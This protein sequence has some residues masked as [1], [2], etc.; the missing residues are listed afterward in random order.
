MAEGQCRRQSRSQF[1][2]S[3]KEAFESI[4]RLGRLIL[5]WVLGGVTVAL[6][7]C[8][9]LAGGAHI[10]RSLPASADTF[11]GL[12]PSK[13]DGELAQ[14]LHYIFVIHGMGATSRNY[15]QPLLD[16]IV[17][18]GFVS[19]SEGSFVQVGLPRP[20]HVTGEAFEC[21]AGT[22]SPPCT[23]TTFGQYRVDRFVHQQHADVKVVVVTYFWDEAMA[24][25]QDPFLRVD[26][27]TGAGAAI[28]TALK[29]NLID[30]GFGDATAYLGA[31]G[32]LA[33]LGISGALCVMLRDASDPIQTP[34]DGISNCQLEGLTTQQIFPSARV[35]YAFLSFS[36]GSRMLYDVLSGMKNEAAHSEAALES[37]LARFATRT[38]NFFMAANQ[39]PLLGVGR[40][41]ITEMGSGSRQPTFSTDSF[42]PS[43][44]GGFFSFAGCL[45]SRS[46]RRPL[47]SVLLDAKAGALTEGLQVIAFHD[48]ADLLGFRASAGIQNP[49]ST[50][51][52]EV[53]HRNTPVILGL[54]AWPP[55]AHATELVHADSRML[56]LC[57]GQANHQ[58]VLKAKQCL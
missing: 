33:R 55:A 3:P 4:I 44:P 15:A 27:Q 13:S 45:R 38:R 10:E 20:V 25:L 12:L 26:R 52:I 22:T 57:G 11:S 17:N 2:G 29:H 53:S 14:G 56:I 9:H 23:F 50:E 47:T 31:A 24:E 41:T 1:V 58:H 8:T 32:D 16:A 35:D 39:M 36:L 43:C 40:V 5:M 28:N 18:Q 37:A 42:L 19:S 49:G 7:G 51:F 6:S 21:A 54:L 46:D 48:P 30:D 34:T